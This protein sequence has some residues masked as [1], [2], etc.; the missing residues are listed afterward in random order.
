MPLTPRSRSSRGWRS[1]STLSSHSLLHSL[2]LG[3][4]SCWSRGRRGSCGLTLLLGLIPPVSIS[5]YRGRRRAPITSQKWS[6][7]GLILSLPATLSLLLH[8]AGNLLPSTNIP[9]SLTVTHLL[10]VLLILVSSFL[11]N[12][13][14]PSFIR[15]ISS[16][17]P[18]TLTRGLC[19]LGLTPWGALTQR[20][21]LGH[22]VVGRQERWDQRYS[23]LLLLDGVGEQILSSWGFYLDF[24]PPENTNL[25]LK[26]IQYILSFFFYQGYPFVQ[27]FQLQLWEVGRGGLHLYLSCSSPEVGESLS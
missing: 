26:V 20:T 14:Q 22:G 19:M 5:F 24:N 23:A 21:D 15:S 13:G 16:H 1:S 25:S 7:E 17:S 10:R 27:I 18:M 11:E 2:N 3:P 4:R 8:L 12:V 6:S 9:C